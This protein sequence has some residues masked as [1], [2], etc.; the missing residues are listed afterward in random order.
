MRLHA[1][2]PTYVH[3]HFIIKGQDKRAARVRAAA[4]ASK[5]LGRLG[6]RP[7][8]ARAPFT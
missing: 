2:S 3:A 5:Y 7:V 1:G 6:V 4:A 8:D